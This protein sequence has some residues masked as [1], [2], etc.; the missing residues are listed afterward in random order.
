MRR[1]EVVFLVILGY[2]VCLVYL[3]GELDGLPL[4]ASNEDLLILHFLQRE[5]ANRPSLRAS[6][7]HRFTVGALRARRM[8]ACS[9]TYPS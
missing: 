7:D 2:L 6:I 9:L 3:E 5:Q 4:R 8:L 1:A